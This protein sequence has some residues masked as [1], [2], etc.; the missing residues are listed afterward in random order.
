MDDTFAVLL[1]RCCVC[2]RRTVGRCAK[3]LVH[4][5]RRPDRRLRDGDGGDPGTTI[6][7]YLFFLQAGQEVEEEHRHHAKPLWV[8]PK[9]A[10]A[11]E[12]SRRHPQYEKW[13]KTEF[14]ECL[15]NS[16]SA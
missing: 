13:L 7:P 14:S 2:C 8:S 9:S 3:V 5:Q 4:S 10:G 6:S 15:R 16:I 12:S 1:C 11:R